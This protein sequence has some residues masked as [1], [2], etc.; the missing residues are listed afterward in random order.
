V[1]DVR[2]DLWR[3]VFRAYPNLRLSGPQDFAHWLVSLARARLH[4]ALKHAGRRK[5]GA[6]GA[7]QAQLRTAAS[8]VMDVFSAVAAP[9]P[10]P[11]GELARHETMQAVRDALQ[12]LT[13]HQRR[14]ISMFHLEGHSQGEIAR[15][16]GMTVPAVKSHL[17]KGRRRLREMLR[18]ERGAEEA[19]S[20]VRPYEPAAGR[21]PAEEA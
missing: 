6:G 14:T 16:L 10:T 21:S 4:D 2:Q 5:R 13:P 9:Q 11:S 17:T 12:R 18:R 1:E 3:C 19:S 15:Q 7:A 20:R 8:S